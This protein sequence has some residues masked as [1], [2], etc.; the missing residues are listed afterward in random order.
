MNSF[1]EYIVLGFVLYLCVDALPQSRIIGGSHAEDDR[2]LLRIESRRTNYTKAGTGSFIT[3]NH[4]LTSAT[5]V[6]GFTS[7]LLEYKTYEI[8][9]Y[10]K[11][12]HPDYN[13]ETLEND[14]GII[15]SYTITDCKVSNESLFWLC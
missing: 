15:V 1:V 10:V 7:F 14:I 4:A 2:H 13:P 9:G 12:N 8:I 11:Y 6:V 3:K 5:Q